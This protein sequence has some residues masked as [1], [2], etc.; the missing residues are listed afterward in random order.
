MLGVRVIDVI[1]HSKL[2]MVLKTVWV[3]SSE[4]MRGELV[5]KMDRGR[6]G[7]WKWN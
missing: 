3:K 6:G 1:L 4:S 5:E 2:E 7:V